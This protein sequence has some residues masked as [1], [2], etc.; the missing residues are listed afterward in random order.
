MN[1]VY[2]AI[3]FAKRHE[4]MEFGGYNGMLDYLNTIG[5]TPTN[6]RFR[7]TSP[8]RKIF[9]AERNG[10]IKFRGERGFD[11]VQGAIR[12]RELQLHDLKGH[13]IDSFNGEFR[14]ELM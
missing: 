7:F 9:T 10:E 6:L 12:I 3:A 14:H 11:T 5:L 8:E 13:I 2:S 4:D 1:I